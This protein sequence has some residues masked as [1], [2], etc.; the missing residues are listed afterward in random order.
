MFRE[1]TLKKSLVN[2]ST[3]YIRLYSVLPCARVIS[4]SEEKEVCLLVSWNDHYK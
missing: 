2:K 1:I 4:Y 3:I